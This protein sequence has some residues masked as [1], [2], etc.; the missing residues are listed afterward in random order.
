MYQSS[1]GEEMKQSVKNRLRDRRLLESALPYVD[2][3]KNES[4]FAFLDRE[5]ETDKPFNSGKLLRLL[6]QTCGRTLPGIYKEE[7]LLAV[8]KILQK[9]SKTRLLGLLRDVLVTRE[10]HDPAPTVP[11]LNDPATA[12][13]LRGMNV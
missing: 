10:R 4:L 3:K 12:S 9:G 7:I 11:N 8:D 13:C 6:D 5:G 2:K 1:K